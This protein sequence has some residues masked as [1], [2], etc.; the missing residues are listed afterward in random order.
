VAVRTQDDEV[1]PCR[2]AGVSVDVVDVECGGTVGGVLLAPPTL[3]ASVARFFE[4]VF[5][6]RL[7]H[8]ERYAFYGGTA[9]QP[10]LDSAS[11]SLFALTA[12]GAVFVIM[13]AD[14]DTAPITIPHTFL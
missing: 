3:R 6:N 5:A 13:T 7:F 9:P 14:G 11:L 4:Q 1:V 2:V 12:I 8:L 10:I